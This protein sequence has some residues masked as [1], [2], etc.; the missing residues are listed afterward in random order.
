MGRNSVL[1]DLPEF[2]IR[3]VAVSEMDNNV[4]LITVKSSGA[5]ILI[6]AADE[7][8]T[9][10]RLIDSAKADAAVAPR[11]HAIV[12][13]HSHWDHI[14]ALK[15]VAQATGATTVAG[16]EDVGQIEVTCGLKIDRHVEHGDYL[17]LEGF[18]IPVIG[19]R[20]HTPGSIALAVERPDQPTHLF[21]GDS[22]FPGGVGN[23]NRDP[24]RFK[25]LWTDV[26]ERLFD[27]YDDDSV[28]HPGHGKPTTLGAERPHLGE[29]AARGW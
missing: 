1:I 13:T 27:C 6:D 23:T 8:S 24:A 16:T 9:C 5:Q 15:E 28:V 18:L 14:R 11:L 12:T 20:G 4:Y 21:T 19:L 3:Q 22:L 2:T 25:S 26:S 29:W 10:L 17:Q 7:P